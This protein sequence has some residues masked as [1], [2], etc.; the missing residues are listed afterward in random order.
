MDAKVYEHDEKMVN[1]V[2]PPGFK[3][4][5]STNCGEKLNVRSSI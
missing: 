1:N 3:Q 5:L 4:I 2:T